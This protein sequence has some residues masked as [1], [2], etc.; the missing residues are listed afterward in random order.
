MLMDKKIDV[1]GKVLNYY[2]NIFNG[3]IVFFVV[4]VL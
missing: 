1:F 2:L 4:L 3:L